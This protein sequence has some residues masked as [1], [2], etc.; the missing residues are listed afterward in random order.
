MYNRNIAGAFRVGAGR[1]SIVSGLAKNLTTRN[2]QLDDLFGAETLV[3][4]EKKKKDDESDT[5]EANELTEEDGYEDV[6]KVGVSISLISIVNNPIY[7][8]AWGAV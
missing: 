4:K 1:K 6:E 5:D 7:C 8:S 3:L 2:H